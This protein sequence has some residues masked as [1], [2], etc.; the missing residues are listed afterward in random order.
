MLDALKPRKKSR[1]SS[2]QPEKTPENAA[3]S[4]NAGGHRQ[5]RR[6][7]KADDEVGEEVLVRPD[8]VPENAELNALNMWVV[9]DGRKCR[10]CPRC[11]DQDDEVCKALGKQRKMYWG[12]EPRPKTCM[13]SGWYCGYCTK[14]RAI[15]CKIMLGTSAYRLKN[16]ATSVQA[17]NMRL[18]YNKHSII[19][20]TTKEQ[21]TTGGQQQALTVQEDCRLR[22][23][24]WRRGF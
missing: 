17:W 7:Q 11:D 23:Q 22:D 9:T 12:Y 16:I 4:S 24:P 18:S 19:C 10:L 13:T 21:N 6:D 1:A 5:Q 20:A 15:S 14:V 8:N 3:G 2:D